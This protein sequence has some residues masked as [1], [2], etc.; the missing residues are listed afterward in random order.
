M[1]DMGR[2]PPR[3]DSCPGSCLPRQP[4]AR[5]YMRRTV[6]ARLGTR[7]DAPAIWCHKRYCHT[8]VGCLSSSPQRSSGTVQGCSCPV[9]KSRNSSSLRRCPRGALSSC[10]NYLCTTMRIL[11]DAHDLDTVVP[12]CT[13]PCWIRGQGETRSP[14]YKWPLLTRGS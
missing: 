13:R 2:G 12:L 3:C 8:S 14:K 4:V 7:A 5:S 6:M 9:S 11:W 10:T 1:Q